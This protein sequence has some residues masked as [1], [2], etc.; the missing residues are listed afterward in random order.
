M[1]MGED[2]L[3]ARVPAHVIL[4]GG[5]EGFMEGVMVKYLPD[6]VRSREQMGVK[7]KGEQMLGGP[8][9]KSRECWDQ[10]AGL[11]PYLAH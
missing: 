8:N 3:A 11:G 2:S 7:A 6:G 1:L 9:R 4:E 5:L 10:R